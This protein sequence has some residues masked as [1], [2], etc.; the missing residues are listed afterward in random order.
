MVPQSTT[1]S[2]AEL[3]RWLLA[4]GW[5][6]ATAESCTGG[7]MGYAITTVPGSGQWFAGGFITYMD[8]VKHDVLGVAKEVIQQHG[9][10]S[11]ETAEAMAC[12]TL[13]QVGVDVAISTTG[14]AGPTGGSKEKP[15][16]LVWFGLAWADQ[17]ISWQH[18]FPGD[19]EA[20]R[21][22]AIEHAL[23]SYKKIP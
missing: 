20:V 7:G 11:A 1:D 4:R 12:H 8:E 14:I 16:G 5:T 18:H 21:I 17:C 22:A 15:V 13:E 3:G 10:V 9:A 23:T 19:R 2:A 6:V